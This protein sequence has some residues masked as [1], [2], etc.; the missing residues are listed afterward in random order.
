MVNEQRDMAAIDASIAAQ[1]GKSIQ[2]N[3]A[4][5]NDNIKLSRERLELIRERDALRA[6]VTELL[7][8]NNEFEERARVAERE[9]QRQAAVI[10]SLCRA[11]RG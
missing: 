9:N 2:L 1:L 6:R 8:F 7:I 4:L 5:T 11:L 10:G 3:A